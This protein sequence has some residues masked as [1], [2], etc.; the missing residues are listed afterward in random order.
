MTGSLAHPESLILGR[1]RSGDGQL[2]IAGRST[3]LH[4]VESAAVAAVIAGAGEGHPWPAQLPPSWH[5]REARDYIRVVPAVVA[6][7]RVDVA[8]AAGGSSDHWR[9]RPRYLRIRTDL[10][11]GD[12]P[13]DLLTSSAEGSLPPAVS[14]FYCED[15]AS[16][17]RG[18]G[19]GSSGHR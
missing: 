15:C 14:G 8:T 13:T 4:A 11:P 1:I 5:E 2:R 19:T 18:N 7:V 6:E 9:H 12:V 10:K 3:E 17:P 16:P